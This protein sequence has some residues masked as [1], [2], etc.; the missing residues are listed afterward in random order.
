MHDKDI[1]LPQEFYTSSLKTINGINFTRREIDI[2]ACRLNRRDKRK[3]IATFLSISENTV[4]THLK[5]INTKIEGK[6]LLDFLESS[7]QH[8]LLK[9]HYIFL[10]IFS[11]FEKSLKE[12]VKLKE[13]RG[14]NYLIVHWNNDPQSILVQQLE[15]DLKLLGFSISKEMRGTQ[16]YFSNIVSETPEEDGVI[17]VASK[18][19]IQKLQKEEN[20]SRT[21]ASNKQLF[22][23]PQRPPPQKSFK[24]VKGATFIDFAEHKNYYFGFLD[25]LQRLLPTLNVDKVKAEFNQKYGTLRDSDIFIAPSSLPEPY[26]MP[27]LMRLFLVGVVL[28]GVGAGSM[29]VVYWITTSQDDFSVRSD[30]TLPTDSARLDRPEL[31]AQINRHLKEQTGI[32]TVALVGPGGAGKTTLARQYAH[33]Q[34]G[35]VW[36]INAETL[37][38]LKASFW[39]FAHA[40]AKTESE[41]EQLREIEDIKDISEREVKLL[42]FIKESLQSHPH[43]TLVFDNVE[44]PTDFH[45][46]FSGDSKTWGEGKILITTR[47]THLQ[48]SKLIHSSLPIE[49]LNP[50]QKISLFT[51]IMEK[52]NKNSS[53]I[54]STKEI[55]QFLE[56]IPSYPLDVSIAA[57]Y[58]KTNNITL[59]EYVTLI[60]QY[61][62][63]FAE[64]Q[65]DILKEVGD[66]LKT[67]YSI[68]SLS[69]DQLI[70]LHPDYA[71]L[72]LF[73]SL[74]DSQAIPQ[75]FLHKYK[76]RED[77]RTFINELKRYSLLTHASISTSPF[78]S[79]LSLHRST[80]AI[81]VAYFVKTLGLE[82]TKT[83]VEPIA[84]ALEHVAE[85]ELEKENT[86]HIKIVLNHVKMFLS[87][88]Q[89]LDAPIKSSL[90]FELGR[91][92]GHLS[93]YEKAKELL[94]Q[95][96]EILQKHNAGNDIKIA[97]ISSYLGSVY[98][99][100]ADP[101][102]SQ[103]LLEESLAIYNQKPE[104]NQGEIAQ[105]L[106]YLGD[107]YRNKGDLIRA[108][109]LLEQSILLYKKQTPLD[110]TGLALALTNLGAV[111]RELRCVKDAIASL[112]ES[113]SL[114]KTYSPENF[115]RIARV[116]YFLGP[117]YK[118]LGDFKKSR[119]I[120][121]ESIG[122]FKK[123]TYKNNIL[124]GRALVHVGNIYREFGEYTHAKDILEQA[125]AIHKIHHTK[126]YV[127]YAWSLLHIGFVERELGESQ[128]A[129]LILEECL[130]TYRKH[131][132]EDNIRIAWILSELAKVHNDLNNYDVAIK[133]LGQSIP[134]HEKTYGPENVETAN[135]IRILAQAHLLKGDLNTAETH[136]KN[137]LR[138]FQESKHPDIY[139]VCEDLADLEL[140]KAQ[141]AKSQEKGQQV[142]VHKAQAIQ[143]LTQARKVIK[144]TFPSNSSHLMRIESKLKNL[145]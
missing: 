32:K 8:G 34:K 107:T 7:S 69:L 143:Y 126:E 72:L 93:Q 78:D 115:M 5:N 59:S 125:F 113:L 66:Y 73:I 62:T 120:L 77:V 22:I 142:E 18:A 25:V 87:H 20:L 3:E 101:Q 15:S 26:K 91:M 96:L 117:T 110:P 1:F 70:K 38:S 84:K 23:L 52:D 80:Q 55:K 104:E 103:E 50:Q 92:Y 42:R 123:Y 145:R 122:L 39:N 56:K 108:K 136:L 75:A 48:N 116:L 131:F 51:K 27:L 9:K 127:Q 88:D 21:P 98:K 119:S 135:V 30:L 4:Q 94:E 95:S 111:Q 86:S 118:N 2:M 46:F 35:I 29:E 28:V 137:I 36:E 61:N 37:E 141:S 133:L 129:K 31:L 100:L 47:N 112:E 138:I 105:T 65:E 132:G 68:I 41:K 17:Y 74:L 130:E 67:R 102:R 14:L 13:G 45:K 6:P 10:Q 60:D 58:L 83:R 12:I 81:I 64:S 49:E 63:N 106:A 90:T 99:E 82:E 40:L 76:S 33:Q 57:Y 114:Y 139:K 16:Q 71:N 89:L 134:I 128:K 144:T 44:K 140:K 121:E 53:P 97:Q 19:F 109:S 85:E 43:W 79:T 11:A 54:A 124:I 24:E